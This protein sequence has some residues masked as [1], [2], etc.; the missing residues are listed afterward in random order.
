MTP[1]RHYLPPLLAILLTTAALFAWA[2]KAE[3]A[4][5]SRQEIAQAATLHG[6]DEC[7][8]RA[9]VAVEAE[10]PLLKSKKP[11]IIFEGD[12]FWK[13]LA[14][15]KIDPKPLE[16]KHSDLLH[17]DWTAKHYQL[18]EKEYERLNRAAAINRD[19]AYCATRWGAFFIPGYAYKLCGFSDVASFAAAQNTTLGQL[20]SFIMYLKG[21]NLFTAAATQKWDDFVTGYH[22]Q[23]AKEGGYDRK[24]AAAYRL[25]A[26]KPAPSGPAK[27]TGSTKPAASAKPA[28]SKPPAETPSPAAAKPAAPQ[29][30]P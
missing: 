12:V 8:L 28:A 5:F 9:I 25:C 1:S 20:Q 13:E 2:G 22:G 29:K 30:T 27:P 10:T 18:G 21:K 26:P 3:A 16:A 24:L 15:R 6:M 11:S 14:K 17:K 19:A 4:P 7:S 23:K